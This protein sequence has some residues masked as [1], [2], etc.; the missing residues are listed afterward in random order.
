MYTVLFMRLTSLEGREVAGSLMDIGLHGRQGI[1]KSLFAT[2]LQRGHIFMEGGVCSLPGIL[3]SGALNIDLRGIRL[4]YNFNF[5]KT[6]NVLN[7]KNLKGVS[8]NK[9]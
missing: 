8:K 1:N 5:V 4:W 3:C 7:P 2:S 9:E 6:M